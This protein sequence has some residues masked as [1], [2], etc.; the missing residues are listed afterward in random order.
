MLRQKDDQDSELSHRH[1]EGV[2][3]QNKTKAGE[4]PQWIKVSVTKPKNW[5]GV[6]AIHTEV[7]QWRIQEP[8]HGG[9][10]I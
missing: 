3:K 4:L 8:E 2:S 10:Q 5:R 9:L 1:K 7:K 6:P